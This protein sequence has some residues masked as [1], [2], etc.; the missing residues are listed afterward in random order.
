M[1]LSLITFLLGTF[2]QGSKGCRT[3]YLFTGVPKQSL[4]MR[5]L[6]WGL[7]IFAPVSE[8]FSVLC[9]SENQSTVSAVITLTSQQLIPVSIRNLL[10][11][12]MS[13][14]V[15][16]VL[17]AGCLWVSSLCGHFRIQTRRCSSYWGHLIVL[18]VNHKHCINFA[19]RFKAKA[20]CLFIGWLHSQS[21]SWNG[22]RTV[23]NSGSLLTVVYI[24]SGSCHT[25]GKK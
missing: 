5:G 19:V 18:G 2:H 13:L 4:S 22:V 15:T 23:R 1:N 9:E 8:V 17:A 21:H 10:V 16:F 20:S 25:E 6:F 7:N 11:L 24:D 3:I 12:L 14:T